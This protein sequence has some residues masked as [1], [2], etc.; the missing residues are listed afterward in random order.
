MSNRNV[1]TS[2]GSFL[3]WA[4]GSSNSISLLGKST[5]SV[6]VAYQVLL[7]EQYNREIKTKLWHEILKELSVQP[8]IS[9]DTAIKVF[10]I[11]LHI[12]FKIMYNV[13]IYIYV[14]NIF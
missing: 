10:Y 4:T 14:F 5:Q 13:I 9:L 2:F 11:V 1:M 3:N 8:K 12:I 7:T 6:W